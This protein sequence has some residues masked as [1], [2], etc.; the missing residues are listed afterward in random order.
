MMY[1]VGAETSRPALLFGRVMNNDFR[2]IAAADPDERA[3]AG[4]ALREKVLRKEHGWGKP[5]ENRAQSCGY[6]AEAGRRED[7]GTTSDP[8]RTDASISFRLRE[9]IKPFC[10][11][12]ANLE[13]QVNICRGHATP[14]S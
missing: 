7:E 1:D 4:K 11:V 8:L 9:K 6:A 2:H 10:K 3:A 14:R 13:Q 5:A 12:K